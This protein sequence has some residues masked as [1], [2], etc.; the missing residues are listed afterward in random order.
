MVAVSTVEDGEM[1][2][3]V[4]RH[5]FISRPIKPGAKWVA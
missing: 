2:G 5:G 4:A 1:L 3:W